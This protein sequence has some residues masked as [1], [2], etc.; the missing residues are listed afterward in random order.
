M[1]G[2][3]I[4]MYHCPECGEMVLA[5]VDPAPL[6]QH[7][8]GAQIMEIASNQSAPDQKRPALEAIVRRIDELETEDHRA[9]PFEEVRALQELAQRALQSE[10][11]CKH[12]CGLVNGYCIDCNTHPTPTPRHE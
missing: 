7:K 10:D 3:P 5:G 6:C 8:A 9:V 4:G 12:L 2:Q 1:K 11:E